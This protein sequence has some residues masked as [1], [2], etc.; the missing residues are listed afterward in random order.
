MRRS[1][2]RETLR[3]VD[4]LGGLP[5]FRLHDAPACPADECQIPGPSK[6]LSEERVVKSESAA[7]P[8]QKTPDRSGRVRRKRKRKECRNGGGFI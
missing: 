7:Q 6:D 4:P 5:R 3:V 2:D 1:R 8:A